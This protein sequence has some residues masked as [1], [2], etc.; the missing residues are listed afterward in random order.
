MSGWF[1]AMTLRILANITRYLEIKQKGGSMKFHHQTGVLS[2]RHT[3]GL[4][5]SL[6]DVPGLIR[7]L[8]STWVQPL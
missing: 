3:Q 4:S 6:R 2:V 8:L 7:S 1:S 5:D